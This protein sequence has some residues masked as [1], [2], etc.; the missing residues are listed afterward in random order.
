MPTTQVVSGAERPAIAIKGAPD[1][2][3]LYL[4]GV[5]M[6]VAN[7]YDGARQTLVVEEGVHVVELRAGGQVLMSRKILASSGET[8]KI[9]YAVG[10]QR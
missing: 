2:A 10:A 3:E 6:G 8:T 1:G 4:D 5:S 9:D 7:R